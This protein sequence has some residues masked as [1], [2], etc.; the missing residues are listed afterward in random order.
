MDP[1]CLK[2]QPFEKP[3]GIA[4]L[5]GQPNTPRSRGNWRTTPVALCSGGITNYHCYTPTQ[6]LPNKRHCRTSRALQ[7]PPRVHRNFWGCAKGAKKALCGE[8]F[9][10][11]AKIDSNMLPIDSKLVGCFKSKPTGGRE[12]NGLST[13]PS[14]V[15]PSAKFRV[16]RAEAFYTPLALNNQ[17][18]ST[19]QLRRADTQTPT[20]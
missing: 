20:R 3:F 12:E 17:K 18:S 16:H 8:T 5:V 1:S 14:W 11:N 7:G 19:S 9:V 15:T 6:P 2:L 10:R 4:A 13:T